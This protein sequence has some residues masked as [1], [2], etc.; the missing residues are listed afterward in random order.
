MKKVYLVLAAAA[1]LLGVWYL[2]RRSTP[3]ESEEAKPVAQVQVAPLRKATL[4]E[5][6]SGFGVV[7]ASPA[8]TH[9]VALAYDA[10][11]LKVAVSQGAAVAKG[12]EVV[13]VGPTPDALLAL[14]AARSQARLAREALKAAHERY[15]LKLATGMDLKTAQQAAGDATDK[16]SSLEARGQSKE[17]SVPAPASGTVT[18][19]DLQ[20][21]SVV[22]AGTALFWVS[23]ADQL[24]AN[25]AVEPS[26]AVRVRS[27]QT[28]EISAADRPEADRVTGTV[29][30]VGSAVDAASGSVSVRVALPAGGQW[31]P[32]EHVQAA[33]HVSQKTALVAPRAAILPEDDKRILYTVRDNTAVKHE[34]QVGITSDQDVEITGKDVAAGDRAVVVGN[35]ELEDGM[36]VSVAGEAPKEGAPEEAKPNP[37]KSP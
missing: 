33:L 25:V 19:L 5:S 10:V 12:D 17:A 22:P 7:E 9:A 4:T 3:A 21:G 32:G 20:A 18:K 34:V 11:V 26:D 1:V 28:A 8:G 24:E 23:G 14:K 27:G 31:Y 30:E 37:G 2:T 16:L 13:H 6:L 36:A 35:Y 15:D 29:R